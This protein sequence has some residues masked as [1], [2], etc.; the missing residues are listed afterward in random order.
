VGWSTPEL[1]WSLRRLRALLL[2]TLF[3]GGSLGLPGIDAALF[4]GSAA[5]APGPHYE[6]PGGCDSHAE[7][8][9]LGAAYTATQLPAVG[10]TPALATFAPVVLLAATAPVRP[11]ALRC[12]RLPLSRA[13]PLLQPLG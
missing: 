13:P 10:A 9:T 3:V 7:R 5:R 4:H 1:R 8:C 6:L 12:R 2:A 11:R